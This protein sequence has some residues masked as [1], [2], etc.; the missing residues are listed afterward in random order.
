VIEDRWKAV[1]TLLRAESHPLPGRQV[2]ERI[3]GTRREG[4]RVDLPR[5]GVLLQTRV[6][7]ALSVAVLA[8]GLTLLTRFNHQPGE[9]LAVQTDGRWLFGFPTPDLSAQ[10]P[11]RA[12]YP[13]L[14]RFEGSRLR[15][16]TWIYQRHD[17]VDG[18]S[19]PVNGWDTVSVL[20]GI[21]GGEPAWIAAS[22]HVT[23]RGFWLGFS[24]SVYLRR[25]ELRP[26][27]RLIF[28]VD[29][30]G[31]LHVAHS[32][33]FDAEAV[34]YAVTTRLRD[35]AIVRPLPHDSGA[36]FA[37]DLWLVLPGIPFAKGWRGSVNDIGILSFLQRSESDV[38]MPYDLRV[39]GAERVKVGAG[40]YLCWKIEVSLPSSQ[41]RAEN[42][43]TIWVDQES[44]ML[45]RFEEADVS[46]IRNVG[47]LVAVSPSALP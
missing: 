17:V 46:A 39:A 1:R 33:Q 2:W 13:L 27:R 34:R 30:T 20:S 38:L 5:T 19:Q 35:T 21:F 45:V 44:G 23:Y 26:L 6:R 4:R 7:F 18:E 47:E 24:D 11:R 3:L 12:Q 32:W 31:Q 42:F 43:A 37:G 40:N 28:H 25:S 22:R 10:A 16:G 9:D 41:P 14:P 8:V 29:M 36:W 15:A